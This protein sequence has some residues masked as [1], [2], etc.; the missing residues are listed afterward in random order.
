MLVFTPVV[1][2]GYVPYSEEYGIYKLDIETGETQLIYSSPLEITNIDLSPDGT[3]FALC[4]HHGDGYEYSEIYTMNID[5][6][7]LTRLTDNDG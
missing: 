3:K 4:M 5:G 1:S 2:G 6:T 7:E